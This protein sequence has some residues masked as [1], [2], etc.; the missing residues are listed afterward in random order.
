MNDLEPAWLRSFDAIARTGSV[1]RAA[2]QVHRTQSA[3]STQLQQLEA[4][5]GARL[6]ERT[7]RTLALTEQGEAF[8]PHARR[9]LALQDEARAAVAPRAAPALWRIGISEYFLPSRLAE[10]LAILRDSQPGARFEITWSSSTSLQ[11]AWDAGEI[12]LAIVTSAAPLPRARL[13]RREPLAWVAAPGHLPAPGA[14]LPLVLLGADCPIRTIALAALTRN[15]VPHHIALTCS[16]SHAATAAI[17]AGWGIGCLNRTAV[18]ADLDVLSRA[19]LRHWPAAGRIS[20]YL[21]A[22]PALRDTERALRRWA[23]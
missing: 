22:R 5:V 23:A 7:T 2:Q 10:L 3:V 20:F 17:R 4:A 6:V 1:T 11:R 15:G 8:L 21:L 14:P 9:L 18:P 12:D 19:S 16:G 13:L